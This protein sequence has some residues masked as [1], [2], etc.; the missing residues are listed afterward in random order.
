MRVVAGLIR[1]GERWLVAQRGPGQRMAGFWEFPGGKI[2]PGESAFEALVRE[3]EE[4]LGLLIQ[5]QK[6]IGEFPYHYDFGEI[7]LVGVLAQ[8]EQ[9]QVQ[10]R[11]HQA[12]RWC[13]L[14]EI[15]H[16]NL[17]PAD[18]PVL[19]RLKAEVLV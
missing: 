4:E 13:E 7:I 16:L 6:I 10:L 11:V 17:A 9:K 2:Q 19:A 8:T 5:P 12:A 18:W 14:E 15:A 1:Y 3:M